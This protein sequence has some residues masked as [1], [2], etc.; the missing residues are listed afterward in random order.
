MRRFGA[1]V[2]RGVNV[3]PTAQVY[4]PWMLEIGE[5]AAVGDG[6]FLY[7]L[8][9]L[10]IGPRATISQRAHLCG[11]SH[12]YT[13]P[14][15]PL[16]RLPIT[17]SADAWVCADAFVGPGVIVGEG[18][19]VGARAAAFKDVAPWTIVGGNPATVIGRRELRLRNLG[20]KRMTL[21]RSWPVTVLIAAK[22]EAV[23]LAK[24]LAAL[25]DFARVVVLD[26]HSTDG[27]IAIAAAHGAEVVQFDYRGGYPKKRQWALDALAIDTPWV[28]L[29]DADEVVPAELMAEIHE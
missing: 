14:A 5:F 7:N 27:T 23:N 12:D 4:F 24:C 8:G 11:G 15:M 17:V 18:A 9:P 25:R 3:S 13:D 26:S 28:L 20:R 6:A 29:L 2:G 16:L 21:P 22:N 1:R 19:V 10:R